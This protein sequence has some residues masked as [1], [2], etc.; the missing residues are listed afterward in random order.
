MYWDNDANASG[1]NISTAAGLGGSGN[2]DASVAKWFNGSV[3]TTWRA[4][5]DAVFLGTAGTVTLAA[6]QSASSLS[7]KTNGYALT[8]S[9]LTVTSGAVSTDTGVTATINSVVAG[10]AGLVK[11]GAGTLKLAGTNTYTGG[12]VINGGVLQVSSDASLGTA[13]SNLT[14]NI[15]LNGG[16][17]QLGGNFDLTSN[18][19]ITLGVNGGTIDTQ[20]FS[21]PGG[22]NATAGGFQGPGNL[23]KIGAGTFFAGASS[24]GLNTVWKGNL[25]IKEGTWKIIATDGLPYNAPVADGLR[26]AQVTLDGGTWQT[27]RISTSPTRDAASPS[28]PAGERSIRKA[29]T[30]PGPVRL[31][32]R[33]R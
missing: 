6:P 17:L 32:A 5:R 8:G 9:T 11:N 25:I 30:S 33:G 19:G 3:D 15:L 22:Y 1:N 20:G 18:G 27:G 2:W 31:R 24:G 23:T 10:S 13:P 16:T 28:P 21:N 7:F 4:G 26:P 12:T 29:S 14:S